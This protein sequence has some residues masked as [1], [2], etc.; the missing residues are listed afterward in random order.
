MNPRPLA[1]GDRVR[2]RRS[3]VED[4]RVGIVVHIGDQAPHPSYGEPYTVS[5]RLDD[6]GYRDGETL[7]YRLSEL[8][9]LEHDPRPAPDNENA[10]GNR[11]NGPEGNAPNTCKEN[12]NMPIIAEHPTSVHDTANLEP[13]TLRVVP[14]VA[15]A[16]PLATAATLPAPAWAVGTDLWEPDVDG[17]VTAFHRGITTAV[18]ADGMHGATTPGGRDVVSVQPILLQVVEADGTVVDEPLVHLDDVPLT[19]SSARTLARTLALAADQLEARDDD[20]TPASA[21]RAP[22]GVQAP[23]WAGAVGPWRWDEDESVWTRD[24][25]NTHEPEGPTGP[26]VEVASTQFVDLDGAVTIDPP[27]VSYRPGTR[28]DDGAL[29]GRPLAEWL[30]RVLWEVAA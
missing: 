30:H 15:L 19:T 5:V 29:H 16:A 26:A 28:D 8:E 1:V 6:G 25:S 13:V 12:E 23:S 10:P 3:H 18:R 17:S 14:P 24:V 27:S 21:R 22:V 20:P 4:Q 9:P 11:C 7:G 2:T